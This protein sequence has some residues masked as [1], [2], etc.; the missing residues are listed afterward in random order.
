MKAIH[1]LSFGDSSV[2]KLTE[3]EKPSYKENEV[4]IKIIATT[5]NPFDIKVR[6]GSM[7]SIMPVELPYV[8]GSDVSGVIEAIGKNVTR[9][10]AGDEVLANSSGGSYAEYVALDQER[11]SLKPQMLSH[12]EAAAMV[13]PMVTSYSLLVEKADL[14]PGQKVLV[15]GAAGGVGSAMVQIAKAMGAYVIGTASGKG[16]EEVKALGADEVL[17]YKTQDFSAVVKDMD[18]VADLVGKDTQVKSFGVLKKGGKLISTVMPPSQELAK[19]YGITAS[20]VNASPS[21]KK[22]DYGIRLVE[23]GR[24]KP[25]LAKIMKL[26]QAAQAQD[27]LAKGGVNGKIA[28]NIN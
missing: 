22:L 23:S 12:P 14:Q 3:V 13:V 24:L 20:F 21:Y 6:T 18:L 26:E 4:L 1:Y 11:V 10:K 8:P 7:Q 17:D 19:K 27:L 25:H 5:V 2:L 28:L 9:L 16:V 15:H